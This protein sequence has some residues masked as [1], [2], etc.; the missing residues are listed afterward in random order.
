MS[1]F[2]VDPIKQIKTFVYHTKLYLVYYCTSKALD[3][4]AQLLCV[5]FKASKLQSLSLLFLFSVEERK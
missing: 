4:S 3:Y 1:G 5:L 2:S